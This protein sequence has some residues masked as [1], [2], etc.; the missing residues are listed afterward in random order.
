MGSLQSAILGFGSLR[1]LQRAGF[2]SF[3][4]TDIV[5][6][7]TTAVATATMP[8][9]AGLVGI[10]PALGL[11][12]PEQNPPAGPIV[13]ST[14]QLLLWSG[15]LAFFGVFLAVPLRTQTIIRCF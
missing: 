10:I 7:Q 14:A 12:S 6:V 3:T 2:S 15:A 1:L 9:A 11:L 4:V 13:L 8:L 5:I